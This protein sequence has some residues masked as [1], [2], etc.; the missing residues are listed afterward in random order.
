MLYGQYV[1][2]FFA[3]ALSPVIFGEV[4]IVVIV[5][6]DFTFLLTEFLS[7]IFVKLGCLVIV[8]HCFGTHPVG[9]QVA[10][11]GV[12]LQELEGKCLHSVF[13]VF[14]FLNEPSALLCDFTDAGN[15]FGTFTIYMTAV[16]CSLVS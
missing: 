4:E 5:S 15:L 8:S 13:A 10:E 12:R 6:F 7:C 11:I 1:C 3:V 2:R 16:L 14:V 9:N